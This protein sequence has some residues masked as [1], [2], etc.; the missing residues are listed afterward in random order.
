MKP[1]HDSP[2]S[3]KIIIESFVSY[4][5][6]QPRSSQ[7]SSFPGKKGEMLP[8]RP[9][10][11]V[12]APMNIFCRRKRCTCSCT[13]VR[14]LPF[15]Q[16][17]PRGITPPTILLSTTHP[18]SPNF[19]LSFFPSLFYM[20]TKTQP[21]AR[22]PTNETPKCPPVTKKS[23]LLSFSFQ[24]PK[25]P[26][27][28][29]PHIHIHTHTNKQL[30][31][32]PKKEKKKEKCKAPKTS[33]TASSPPPHPP[34]PQPGNASIHPPPPSCR[35]QRYVTHSLTLPTDAPVLNPAS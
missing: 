30:A 27:P 8:D 14:R 15:K 17:C 24:T 35:I 22:T 28:S 16:G 4:Y 13:D 18:P 34:P 7:P 1:R 23:L 11:R 10:D 9:G 33:S 3:A 20:P 25:T 26:P 12:D 31:R 32:I 5:F 29:L 21:N 6:T 19:F 2:L